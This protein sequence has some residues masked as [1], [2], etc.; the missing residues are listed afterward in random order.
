MKYELSEEQVKNIFIFLNRVDLKGAEAAALLSI[1]NS[2]S[3]PIEE[4]K[5]QSMETLRKFLS[6]TKK[7]DTIL[8]PVR[9][10]GFKT[11]EELYMEYENSS[12]E[13]KA[14]ISFEGFCK[15]RRTMK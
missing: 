15:L 5:E 12:N 4:V 14:M 1:I 8:Y 7:R 10:G 2:L 11:Q 13:L 6:R 3:K 9:E